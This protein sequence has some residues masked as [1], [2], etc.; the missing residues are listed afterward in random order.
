VKFKN[1]DIALIIGGEGRGLSPVLSKKC[2]YLVKI[3]QSG[4]IKSL[5]ASVAAGI[6]I[7]QLKLNNRS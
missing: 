1:M 5:N 4:N 2:D 6:M 3:S 7:Y